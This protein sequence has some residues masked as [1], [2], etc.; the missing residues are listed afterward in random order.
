MMKILKTKNLIKNLK[1]KNMKIQNINEENRALTHS[2]QPPDPSE[3]KPFGD[4]FP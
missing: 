4:K 3:K 1:I 2:S